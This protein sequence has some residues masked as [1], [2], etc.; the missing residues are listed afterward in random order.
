MLE[1][2]KLTKSFGDV[3]ALQS[4]NVRIGAGGFRTQTIR[5]PSS[6]RREEVAG[7]GGDRTC[8]ASS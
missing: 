4:L 6:G 8:G 5:M 1:A 2:R 7:W 3:R